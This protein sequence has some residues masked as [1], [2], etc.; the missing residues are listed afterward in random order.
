LSLSFQPIKFPGAEVN[1]S[2]TSIAF[3]S[4]IVTAGDDHPGRHWSSTVQIA[5]CTFS[6][7]TAAAVSL[8]PSQ[9]AA[10][11]VA[12][13]SVYVA[14][15]GFSRCFAQ[16]GGAIYGLSCGLAIRHSNFTE[17]ASA[18]IGGAVGLTSVPARE[19]PSLW[20]LLSHTVFESCSSR[21][22]AGAIGLDFVPRA[23]RPCGGRNFFVSLGFTFPFVAEES[24]RVA[25]Q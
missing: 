9:G 22:S 21:E 12:F 19:G 7:L 4:R 3:E 23:R 1:S 13:C 2:H 14:A 8:S 11:W 5:S 17:C 20:L 10:F 6:N 15:S 18:F 16:Y 25:L 24:L